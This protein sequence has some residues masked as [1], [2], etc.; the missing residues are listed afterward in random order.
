MGA[1]GFTSFFERIWD[2][3]GAI[4]VVVS[5]LIKLLGGWVAYIG[6]SWCLDSTIVGTFCW[7]T[8]E[9]EN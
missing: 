7:P 9:C 4:V 3:I 6:E 5:G 2:F 1:D 8:S